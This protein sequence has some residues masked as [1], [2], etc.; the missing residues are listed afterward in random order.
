MRRLDRQ[1]IHRA[2]Q[3][4]EEQVF[5]TSIHHS[6]LGLAGTKNLLE[7]GDP[8]AKSVMGTEC[9]FGL[10]RIL[11]KENGKLQL[12]NLLSPSQS[13]KLFEVRDDKFAAEIIQNIDPKVWK[14]NSRE[15]TTGNNLLHFF[16]NEAFYASLEYLLDSKS[17]QEDLRKLVFQENKAGNT[18]LMSSLTLNSHEKMNEISQKL[19]QIMKTD[20]ERL[21]ESTCTPNKR[22]MTVLHLSAQNG[23]KRASF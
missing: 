2:A 11:K 23:K 15:E 21:P 18:P 20:P 3:S 19:L 16:I 17:N 7:E 4:F 12:E 1:Q 9:I 22:K 8:D 6:I 13:S 10:Q 5:F 14:I